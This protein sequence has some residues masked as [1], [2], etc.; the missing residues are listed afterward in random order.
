M[1]TDTPPTSA[2]ASLP[3]FSTLLKSRDV[4]DPVNLWVHRPLAYAIV[5]LIYRTRI[6]PNQIT[7]LALLVGLLAAVLFFIGTPAMML[8]GGLLLWSSAILD[9]ADGI[10]ARAKRI[11]SDIGRA[12]DGFADGMVALATVPMAFYHLW[13][14]H[15]SWLEVA[16]M[17]F[18]IGITLFHVYLYD[19]YKEAYLQHT[20]PAWN[21]NPERLAEIDARV[22]RVRAEGGPWYARLATESYVGIVQ[23]QIRVVGLT[24]PAAARHHLTFPVTA[25]SVRIYREYNRG[26]MQV[27]ALISLAP[28]SY[29]ISL[30]AMFDHLELYLW[31]RV[32][33]ANA[34]F[35]WALVWQRF[36]TRK[37]VAALAAENLMPSPLA[38]AQPA[39]AR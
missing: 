5:A 13:V 31:F 32:F 27:W 18:A 10:L 35:V 22:A 1:A 36:A 9:G 8:A 25:E 34:L 19:Y 26:P 14:L 12:I 20:N 29:L 15:H 16:L 37:T 24:N 21:G 3:P 33:G 39:N 7:L 28:H 2:P 17:P 6:T 38:V 30:C 4:E 11:Q 23:N